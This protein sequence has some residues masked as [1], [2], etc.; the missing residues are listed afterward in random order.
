MYK[1]DIKFPDDEKIRRRTSKLS[2]RESAIESPDAEEG[3]KKRRSSAGK[4]LSKTGSMRKKKKEDG[5]TIPRKKKSR[6][7]ENLETEEE[8]QLR[9]SKSTK[10]RSKAEV[11]LSVDVTPTTES[12]SKLL[13]EIPET[14]TS[15]EMT[16]E[17]PSNGTTILV[18]YPLTDENTDEFG[19][20]KLST[21]T[22]SHSIST[23]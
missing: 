13:D 14:K 10:R 21:T 7:E 11:S 19:F 20:D 5:D 2:K 6:D 16:A 22:V 12:P 18:R 17:P 23:T 4:R 3:A 1:S 9:K 15:L 8:R